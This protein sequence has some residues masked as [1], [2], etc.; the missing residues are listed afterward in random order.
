MIDP[1]SNLIGLTIL[2]LAIPKIRA[3]HIADTCMYIYTSRTHTFPSSNLLATEMTFRAKVKQGDLF[4]Y[5]RNVAIIIA[6]TF[7]K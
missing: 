2:Y 6:K 7:V 1:H 4:I 3:Q 5:C